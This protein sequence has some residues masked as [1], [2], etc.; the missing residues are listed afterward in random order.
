VS[1][2]RQPGARRLQALRRKIGTLQAVCV[3]AEPQFEPTLLQTVVEGTRAKTG[4][5]D[6]LGAGIP[7]GPDAYFATMR[8]LARSLA[9]CLSR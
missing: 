7:P 9:D 6:Y 5:L 1:P 8:A 2:E 4:V 3:F